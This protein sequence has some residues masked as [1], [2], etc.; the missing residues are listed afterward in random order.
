MT[1]ETT[2]HEA[3]PPP[4][5]API[6]PP[7]AAY[8]RMGLVAGR[9]EWWRPVAG[10]GMVFGGAFLLML[11]VIAVTET[12][13]VVLDRPVDAEGMV[14][15]GGLG[16]L[17]LSL[18]A[19]ALATP[20]VL[21]AAYAVQG[22]APGTV[23][24]V[25]GRL[26]WRRLAG[27]LAPALPLALLTMGILALLPSPPD[28]DGGSEWAGTSAFLTALAVLWVLVP[29]QAA[30]E[31]YMFRGWLLQAV[32]SWFRSPW[33]AIA[34]QAVLFAA[35]HGWG[36]VWGFADL[37]VFGLVTG[38]LTVRTGG[39]EAAIALHV[40]NNLVSMSIAAAFAG[41]LDSDETA[42]DMDA[43]AVAV[44][45]PVLLLYA[46]AVLWMTRRRERA[47]GG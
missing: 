11:V 2:F 21:L 38:W 16:D 45:V 19:I 27:C 12:A 9:H 36:T 18:L 17:A 39:L 6:P 46:A 3:A 4:P 24:S 26:R 32:G 22:R 43:A 13:G 40:L 33:V 35:A 8:H 25:E 10:T 14:T 30:A 29:F 23:A 31:E 20:V 7:P 1:S 34:P 42:A 41:G 28:G 47:G 5:A 37:V 44:D 15:W